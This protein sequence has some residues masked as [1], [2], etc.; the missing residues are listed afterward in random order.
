MTKAELINTMASG[1]K[2]S[3]SAAAKALEAFFGGIKA[4][5]KKDER[6]T[7]VGFGSFSVSKRKARKGRNPRT[8]KEI[9]I[10]ARRVPK[11]TAGKSFKDEI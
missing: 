2:I 9:N 8:G 11:F 5:L 4:A 6:V 3:K 10:S 1:A 7:L